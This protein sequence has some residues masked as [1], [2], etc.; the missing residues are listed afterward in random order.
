MNMVRGVSVPISQA[1]LQW[2]LERSGY[3]AERFASELR[4]DLELVQ[5]WLSG[6]TKPNLTQFNKI[7]NK[8]RRPAPVFFMEQPPSGTLP[9]VSFRAPI[10]SDRSAPNPKELRFLREASRLQKTTSWILE[11]LDY[12]DCPLP[13]IAV[14]Q[15][16]EV[17]AGKLRQ[18]LLSKKTASSVSPGAPAWKIWR[19]RLENVGVIVLALPLGQA[20]SR[21]FSLWDRKS[22]LIAVNTAWNNQARL[23]SM[24]HEVGHLVTR[25][26]SVCV[27]STDGRF[28]KSPDKI[29]RWVER[30]S[31]SVLMPWTEMQEFLRARLGIGDATQ[32]RDLSVAKKIANEFDV[33]LRAS[34]I[35]LIEHDL[36]SW[37]LYREIPPA[38]DTKR[39]GGGGSGRDRRQK[40][41]DEYG[42]HTMS[43]FTEAVDSGLL[44][45]SEA[46]SYLNIADS[47]F[48]EVRRAI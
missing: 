32:I 40:R 21:G 8:L 22:P 44:H 46:L 3:S 6:K 4:V 23:F 45:R 42:K 33:S 31:A 27:E 12:P 26:Q 34:V 28:S 43:V 11:E 7:T 13:R 30:F 10:D 48:D 5:E 20:S 35:R 15:S 24:F 16:P 25:T 14:N 2:A 19:E 17:A 18:L 9:N 37:D 38:S 29:E 39:G 41:L 36:A 1:A 47:D